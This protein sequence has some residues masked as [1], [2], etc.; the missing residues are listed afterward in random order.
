MLLR[1]RTLTCHSYS[2]ISSNKLRNMVLDKSVVENAWSCTSYNY[3]SVCILLKI[4]FQVHYLLLALSVFLVTGIRSNISP[5]TGLA[6]I[7]VFPYS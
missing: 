3:L 4:L 2:V 1:V 5:Q 7:Q 6:E